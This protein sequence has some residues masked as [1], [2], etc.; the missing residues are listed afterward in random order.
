MENRDKEINES[1][2]KYSSNWG[3][4]FFV[5]FF[6]FMFFGMIIFEVMNK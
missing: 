3:V 2:K 5:G 1:Q 4:Y 6:A